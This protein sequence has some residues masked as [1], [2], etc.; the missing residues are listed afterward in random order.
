MDDGVPGLFVAL[1]SINVALCAGLYVG[2]VGFIG[3]DVHCQGGI[4]V[5]SYQNISED[6]FAV[7]GY[8]YADD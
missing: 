8:A 7:A 2:G 5:D 1:D 4:W 6:Q 3:I